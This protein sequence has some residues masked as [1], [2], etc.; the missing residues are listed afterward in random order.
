MDPKNLSNGGELAPS[1][2]ARSAQWQRWARVW[3]ELVRNLRARDLL[4]DLEQ[5]EVRLSSESYARVA[6]GCVA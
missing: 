2:E 3:N 4:S 6:M 5:D 1:V